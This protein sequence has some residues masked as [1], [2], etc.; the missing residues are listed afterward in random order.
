MGFIVG[1]VVDAVVVVGVVVIMV[2][3]VAAEL[4][5]DDWDGRGSSSTPTAS[6]GLSFCG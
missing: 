2:V 1:I 5:L 4:F 3:V 6:S